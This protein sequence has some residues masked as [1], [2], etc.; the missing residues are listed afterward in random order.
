ME[1]W[2]LPTVTRACG[3][4]QNA[5]GLLLWSNFTAPPAPPRSSTVGKRVPV[6]VAVSAAGKMDQFDRR[7]PSATRIRHPGAQ[8]V[9]FGPRA[10]LCASVQMRWSCSN[11]H[12]TGN[13][14]ES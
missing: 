9:P 3:W 2:H 7:F 13:R 10:R 12:L 6:Y 1:C 8:P 14:G 5:A 11:L 4:R